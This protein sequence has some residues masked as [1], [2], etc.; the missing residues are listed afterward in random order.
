[1]AHVARAEGNEKWLHGNVKIDAKE[2]MDWIN[3]AH[4]MYK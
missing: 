3:L 1:V 2:K 4:D